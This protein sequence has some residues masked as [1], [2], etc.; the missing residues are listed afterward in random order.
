MGLLGLRSRA[1]RPSPP[2][3]RTT[4]V[5]LKEK[6]LAAHDSQR[7]RRLII[8]VAIALRHTGH[9]RQEDEGA[10]AQSIATPIAR[11]TP[12][13]TSSSSTGDTGPPR[14]D[15]LSSRLGSVVICSHLSTESSRIPPVPFLSRTWVGATL[16]VVLAGITSTSSARRFRA[17]T[18]ITRAGRRFSPG[19]PGM[20]TQ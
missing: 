18:E 15:S 12:R 4:S 16:S 2:R 11:S 8:S 17:P 1:N 19:S 6:M 14:A 20:T 7:S 3:F 9:R 5:D 13:S 10:A